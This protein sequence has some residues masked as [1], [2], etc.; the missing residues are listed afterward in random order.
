MILNNSKEKADRFQRG[1]EAIEVFGCL[2]VVFQ[3]A[4]K[5]MFLKDFWQFHIGFLPK[6]SMSIVDSSL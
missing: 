3:P 2:G 4:N 5:N 1:I 6:S